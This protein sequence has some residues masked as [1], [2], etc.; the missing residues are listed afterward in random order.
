MKK[1]SI[2]L[3]FPNQTTIV[4]KF[5]LTSVICHKLVHATGAE[6][7]PHSLCHNLAGIDVTDEL[8]DPLRGVCALLQED[9]WSGL[10]GD[11]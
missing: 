4:E 2:T 3:V 10:R 7:G 9:D 6:G 1:Q 8:W 5:I 11:V